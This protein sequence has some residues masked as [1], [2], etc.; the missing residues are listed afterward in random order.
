M[1]TGFEIM[2]YD[3]NLKNLWIRR[4]LAGV[5][6]FS[7]TYVITFLIVFFLKPISYL[8]FVY[9]FMLQGPVW[10]IYSAIFDAITG[11]TA[12]KYIFKIRAVAFIGNLSIG[13]AIARNIT[14]LNAI[15]VL[16]DAITGLSTEGDPRQ[17]YTERII[18]SLVISEI[19]PRRI[20][21]FEKIPQKD[22]ELVLPR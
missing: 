5:V 13:Q 17:R 7:I 1:Q 22:E 8:D 12:G 10:F 19:R 4:F 9:I 21:K 6:D 14:K 3:R 16:A 15:L 2:D 18:D 20:R 11:K